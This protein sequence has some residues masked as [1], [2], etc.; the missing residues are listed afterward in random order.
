MTDKP[1]SAC[2]GAD[3]TGVGPVPRCTKCGTLCDLL[4]ESVRRR[5]VAEGMPKG[6]R[7]AAGLLEGMANAEANAVRADALYTKA[8]VIRAAAE[9]EEK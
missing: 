2:C 8:A 7:K 6:M 5:I 9:K 3:I 1:V 4:L